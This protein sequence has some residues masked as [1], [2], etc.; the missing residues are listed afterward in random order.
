[1]DVIRRHKVARPSLFGLEYAAFCEANRDAYLRYALV[2]IEDPAEA[3]R[4]VDAVFDALE[5]S[6]IAVLA[7]ECPAARVWR[8]LRAETDHRMIGAAGRRGKFHAVLRDDQADIMLLHR[9]L[10]LSVDHAASL[11]GLAAHD[12]RALLRG[13]ER[14]LSSPLNH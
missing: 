1:M 4:C 2:R 11:M 10:R 8:D 3:R 6:W 14:A 9:H 13:A 12:A 5:T 7:S